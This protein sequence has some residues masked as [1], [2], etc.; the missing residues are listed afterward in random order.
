MSDIFWAS[1]PLILIDSSQITHIWPTPK[2]H[3]I[4]KLNAITRLTI[5]LTVLGYLVHPNTRIIMIGIA[6]IL[7]IVL[8]QLGYKKTGNKLF[9]SKNKVVSNLEGF[10]NAGSGKILSTTSQISKEL[11]SA[12]SPTT[13]ENPMSN[14]LLTDIQDNPNKKAAPPSFLP[15]VHSNITSSAKKMV[16]NVNKS[17][18]NIDKRIFSG[19]GENFDFDTSMRQFTSTA[20]TRIV[21]DQ[22]AFAQF[23]Y[24]NMPSCKDGDVMMCGS[25]DGGV[26]SQ[27]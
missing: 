19:L 13:P 11:N 16:E 26:P 2:M 6:T 15:E 4:E 7:I 23:L 22:G 9:E 3:Y 27:R 17:N 24:G 25:I 20:N 12:F 14:V 1:K 10:G 8:I 21:N 5:V 18:P